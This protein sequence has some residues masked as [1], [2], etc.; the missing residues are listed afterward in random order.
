MNLKPP[1]K[2]PKASSD[3]GKSA[4]PSIESI[5]RELA[6]VY[7]EYKRFEKRMKG[8]AANKKDRQP[9]IKERFF[10]EATQASVA[11]LATKTWLVGK[12]KASDGGS[13]GDVAL[14]RNPGWTV[15]SVKYMPESMEWWVLLKEDPKY[16]PFSFVDKENKLVWTKQIAG[17]SATLDDEQLRAE[18]PELW[19][20]I[21]KP[22]RVMKSL[23]DLDPD[24]L[25]EVQP[26]I[27]PG[28]LQIKLAAP[29]KAKP[30]DL[31][32]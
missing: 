22:T 11:S 21:S 16:K 2:P 17:T 15:E 29:K 31:D 30:E 7:R 27:Y 25:A 10:D 20:R 6:E 1:T 8:D 12:E 13:A 9:G 26:Y 18:N 24:T 28:P 4:T 3:S 32:D 14:R 23:E 19:E 5:V